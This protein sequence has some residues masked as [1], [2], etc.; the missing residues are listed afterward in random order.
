LSTL[1]L[2]AGTCGAVCSPKWT[3]VDTHSWDTLGM[4]AHTGDQ[5]PID[6]VNA[7][8]ARDL[9][10][11]AVQE[12]KWVGTLQLN[13]H[14]WEVNL[15]N[16]PGGITWEQEFFRLKQFHFHSPSE[17]TVN[18]KHFDM[19]MHL[20]H[21]SDTGDSLVVGYFFQVKNGS[22]NSFLD[23]F[24]ADFPKDE[25][26]KVED[27]KVKSWKGDGGVY[28]HTDRAYYSFMGS[29]TT[30]PCT[31]GLRWIVFEET[32]V[33]SER[34]LTDYRSGIN[35]ASCSQLAVEND[36]PVGVSTPWDK[37]LGVNNRPTQPLGD[38]VVQMYSP[39][40]QTTGGSF[41]GQAIA[42]FLTLLLVGCLGMFA[43]RKCRAQAREVSPEASGYMLV[44]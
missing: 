8:P 42:L 36:V 29:L 17:N 20:V 44:C 28:A 18:G 11:L 25:G 15:P 22:T 7:V 30:P 43:W 40:V 2:A 21:E 37:S 1:A 27:F 3:Y 16:E 13:E 14:T 32:L 23:A 12:G 10:P 6:L 33:I 38:R 19:E 24:W 39:K 34:Q 4:C 35:G 41:I 26:E 5:A 9:Q 31:N